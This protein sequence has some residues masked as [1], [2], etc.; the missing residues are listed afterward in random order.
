MR[1]LPLLLLLGAC[2]DEG[3]TGHSGTAVGNPGKLGMGATE[4]AD[5]VLLRAE[6][7]VQELMLLRCGDGWEPKAVDRVVDLLEPGDVLLT[8]PGGLWCGLD[9]VL[10]AEG[11]VLAGETTGGT[12]FEVHLDPGRVALHGPFQVDGNQLLVVYPVGDALDAEVLEDLG[13]DVVLPADDPLAQ[14]W[15]SVMEESTELWEDEDRDGVVDP[16]E[17]LVALADPDTPAPVSDQA[18]CGCGSG[19]SGAVGWL[20]LL[21]GVAVGWRRR[22]PPTLR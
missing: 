14:D 22:R 2:Y 19:S 7:D 13:P 1:I 8:L 3:P 11:L 21:A 15:A 12:T 5:M 17:N 4:P 20:V 9:V 18:G 6:A 16:D 10:A